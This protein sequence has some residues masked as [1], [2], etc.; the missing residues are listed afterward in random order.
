MTAY[1]GATVVFS[2]H[3]VLNVCCIHMLNRL[4][5]CTG[6]KLEIKFHPVSVDVV[7]LDCHLAGILTFLYAHTFLLMEQRYKHTH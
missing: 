7:G 4:N 3:T 1:D 2:A 5:T 6:I